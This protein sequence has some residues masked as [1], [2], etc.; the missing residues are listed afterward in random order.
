MIEVL[1][2]FIMQKVFE[3]FSKIILGKMLV[4]EWNFLAYSL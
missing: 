3:V 4:R 2:T 1:E